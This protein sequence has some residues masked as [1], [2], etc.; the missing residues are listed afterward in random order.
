MISSGRGGSPLNFSAN[1][2]SLSLLVDDKIMIVRYVVLIFLLALNGCHDPADM[3]HGTG[4]RGDIVGDWC[5]LSGQ[6]YGEPM[7][8]LSNYSVQFFN[9]ELSETLRITEVTTFYEHGTYHPKKLHIVATGGMKSSGVSLWLDLERPQQD[10]LPV[11]ATVS[12]LN[13]N[14]EKYVRVPKGFCESDY[15][16]QWSGPKK[17][18]N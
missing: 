11:V 15:W 3:V 10:N 7:F 18:S 2:E 6:G 12:G 4:V 9:E 5:H 8:R 1:Q 13:E 17:S 16:L 14:S